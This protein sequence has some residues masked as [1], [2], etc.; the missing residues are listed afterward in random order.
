MKALPGC[1]QAD[2]ETMLASA[3]LSECQEFAADQ[4]DIACPAACA[5]MYTALGEHCYTQLTKYMFQELGSTLGDDVVVPVVN[6]TLE[7]CEMGMPV[8]PAPLVALSQAVFA[9]YPACASVDWE[10]AMGSG[11][12]MQEALSIA[13]GTCPRDCQNLL[14]TMGV[15]CLL[16]FFFGVVDY[17]GGVSDSKK[18]SIEEAVRSG[19]SEC[20]GGRRRARK[21]LAGAAAGL[22]PEPLAALLLAPSRVAAIY[23][24]ALQK[25][26]RLR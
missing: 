26:G 2:W 25:P 4:A 16:Q 9:P 24:G 23:A 20:V 12:S 7:A 6:A 5:K 22:Q 19:Y 15:D 3:T 8:D 11:C 21:M 10:A 1:E 18:A 14:S 13:A 17:Q